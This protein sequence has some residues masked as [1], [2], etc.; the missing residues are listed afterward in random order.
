MA[1]V[2]ANIFLTPLLSQ[3]VGFNR[4]RLQEKDTMINNVYNTT[5][6]VLL[7]G[8]VVEV[9]QAQTNEQIAL[10]VSPEEGKEYVYR[11]KN[12]IVM[13]EDVFES[14][15]ELKMVC[16]S[17]NLTAG[18]FE[19]ILYYRT[20]EEEWKKM[21]GMHILDSRGSIVSSG[22]D[23]CDSCPNTLNLPIQ[24]LSE[25]NLYPAEAIRS[26]DKWRHEIST[27]PLTMDTQRQLGPGH[28]ILSLNGSSEYQ[29]NDIS[30][31]KGVLCAEI[32]YSLEANYEM[33]MILPN[34]VM[35]LSDAY[36]E[37]GR[38]PVNTRMHGSGSKIV[39]LGDGMVVEEDYHL[40]IEQ[41][42]QGSSERVVSFD[43]YVLRSLQ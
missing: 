4:N 21:E 30:E 27:D 35:D 28:H 25:S 40:A 33:L 18:R 41:T 1:Q 31:K 34:E 22:L 24:Q 6:F 39:R 10:R 11:I 29:L 8:V 2:H 36:N 23:D 43:V 37:S 32:E 15:S 20:L 5:L 17:T 13:N 14:E 19:F 16:V 9:S 12:M 38:I 7:F 42:S 26:G 3:I